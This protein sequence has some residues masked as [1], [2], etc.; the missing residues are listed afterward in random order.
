MKNLRNWSTAIG[1]A[2]HQADGPT[3]LLENA[4]LPAPQK[5]KPKPDVINLIRENS[6][7]KIN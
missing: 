1:S 5:I 7:H 4:T 3:Q 6:K 2:L